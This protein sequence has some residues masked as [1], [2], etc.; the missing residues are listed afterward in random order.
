[1]SDL[2]EDDPLFYCQFCGGVSELRRCGG[3][4]GVF[5]CSREHQRMH[6]PAHKHVCRR[7]Q[8][9]QQLPQVLQPQPP[10]VGVVSPAI[11]GNARQQPPLVPTPPLTP[12][13]MVA[14]SPNPP[15]PPPPSPEPPAAALPGA[16]APTSSVSGIAADIANYDPND[17]VNQAWWN[18]TLS[19]L[20][21]VAE[22]ADDASAGG[23]GGDVASAAARTQP[24]VS[25]SSGA[26]PKLPTS[27]W[28]QRMC[29]SVI[30]DL[31]T[32]GICVIDDFLGQ[33]RGTMVLDEVRSLYFEGR[34]FREG[35]LVSERGLSGRVIRGDQIVW[36]E[37][38]EPQCPMVG[39]LVRTL[40]SI[41]TRCNR[42]PRGGLLREYR[43]NQRTK[44]MIACYPGC[45]T[46]YVKHVDNP[47]K[48]GRCITSIYYLN[49]DWDVKTQGGLLRMFPL[50]QST[51]VANIDPLFDRMLFFWSDRR[52]PHEVLPAYSVRF[53][54]TVWYFDAEERKNALQKFQAAPKPPSMQNYQPQQA[55]ML[56]PFAFAN[57]QQPRAANDMPS[58]SVV[59]GQPPF[60]GGQP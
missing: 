26:V 23:G 30:H 33:E 47:N 51:K 19:S 28:L 25:S 21:L 50:G 9:Q 11:V 6:W 44:A 38:T 46:H 39:F 12:G 35:Q 34:L 14:G 31:N 24:S 1:M 41:I 59:A 7:V 60:G 55:S 56:H 3:C 27:K 2:P 29:N 15:G 53:A 18:D 22:G 52:N 20:G 5:Y 54:I 45:G 58:S 16:A 42:S 4:Q 37:G 40:D 10:A 8:A 36:L 13:S 49:K 32:F 48:D 57:Y 17:P 43:I